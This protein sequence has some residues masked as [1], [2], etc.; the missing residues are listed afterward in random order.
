MIIDIDYREKELFH[1]C[2]ELL[3]NKHNIFKN[4]SDSQE[5]ITINQKKLDIGDIII[6]SDDNILIIIE[7]KS[8][9]DLSSSIKDG[10][11]REQ[12]YRLHNSNIH[13]HNIIY[14]IEGDI[15]KYQ[16]FKHKYNKLT[17][18]SSYLSIIYYKGFSLFRTDNIYETSIFIINT[19]LKIYRETMKGKK[20]FYK[21]ENKSHICA[22]RKYME[23]NNEQEQKLEEKL[24]EKPEE[25]EQTQHNVKD[26]YTN[27]ELNDKEYVQVNKNIKKNN[28]T[29]NNIG[30]CML[31]QIPGIS[32]NTALVILD[33]FKTIRNMLNELNT[34]KD[35]L[36]DIFLK[37]KNGKNRKLSK[38][39]INNLFYFFT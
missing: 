23:N 9:S 3:Q 27:V 7:R 16:S 20:E 19:A 31:C 34:N 14:L 15:G 1:N 24:E 32:S 12:S 30:E 21:N 39:I 2:K 11:Y 33:K 17:L 28:I 5:I 38:K 26:N 25:K 29:K 6:S 37:D 13:N 36:N 4:Y 8:I 22:M 10:R 18:Y 35:C